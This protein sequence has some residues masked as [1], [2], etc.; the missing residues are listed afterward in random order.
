MVDRQ[1]R[2]VE[3][4]PGVFGKLADHMLTELLERPPEP[5]HPAV[6]LALDGQVGKVVRPVLTDRGE[7]HPLARPPE[8]VSDQRNGEDLGVGARWGWSCAARDWHETSAQGI[9]DQHEDVDKQ[10]GQ[11]HHR[12]GPPWQE[13]AV[14]SF[15]ARGGPLLSNQPTSRV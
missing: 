7:E 4:L 11:W 14:H 6:A 3:L 9:V 12:K 1:G 13:V 2:G 5:A 10:A 8:Q 15:S